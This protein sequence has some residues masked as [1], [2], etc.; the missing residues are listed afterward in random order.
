[1]G[2]VSRARSCH[3][4]EEVRGVHRGFFSMKVLIDNVCEL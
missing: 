3:R 2:M 1:M 4:Q